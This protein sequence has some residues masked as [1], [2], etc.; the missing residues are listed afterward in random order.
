VV[1]L[2]DS[3]FS[4]G[5]AFDLALYDTANRF[6]IRPLV[7]RTL[8]TYLELDRYLDEGTP[9]YADYSFQP[10]V[11]SVDILA[12]FDGERRQ[13]LS[14]LLAQASKR[15]SWFSI[16]LE[17]SAR[18]LGCARERIVKALDWLGE[19]QLLKVEVAGV[20]N[21]FR[22]L[23]EP[24]DRSALAAELHARLLNRERAELARLA[25]VLDLIGSPACRSRQLG[26]HFGETLAHDCGHCSACLGESQPLPHRAAQTIEPELTARLAPLLKSAGKALGN[27]RSLTR[28]LCGCSSPALT[29]ARLGKHALFGELCD[30]P[31][32]QVLEWSDE[33]LSNH[34][35]EARAQRATG[36]AEVALDSL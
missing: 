35:C 20:R 29:R 6:D 12:R 28:F 31:F 21:C 2:V 33:L 5:D 25:Q 34:E 9:Y 13:F 27:A 36:A 32:A 3:L 22:R 8:L 14:R 23:R 15:R 19:Q 10:I 16:N 26:A 17:D 24:I 1:A 7:L 4:S 30:V 18:H 11:S